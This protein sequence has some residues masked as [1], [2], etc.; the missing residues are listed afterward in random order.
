[1]QS[2]LVAIKHIGPAFTVNKK[3]L[4]ELKKVCFTLLSQWPFYVRTGAVAPR[5]S[6]YHPLFVWDKIAPVLLS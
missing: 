4:L 2:T 3:L 1:M 6:A 5:I